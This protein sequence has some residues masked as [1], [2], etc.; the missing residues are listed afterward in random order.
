[1]NDDLLSLVE[2]DVLGW[3]G[4]SSGPGRFGSVAFFSYGRLRSGASTVT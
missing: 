2:R 3:P 1:M 4:T